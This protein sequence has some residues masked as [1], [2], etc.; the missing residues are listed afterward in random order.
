MAGRFRQQCGTR[1]SSQQLRRRSPEQPWLPRQRPCCAEVIAYIFTHTHT[2]LLIKSCRCI[3][4]CTS[5]E[6]TFS[7]NTLYGL[8]NNWSESF[9]AFDARHFQAR[10]VTRI[11]IPAKGWETFFSGAGGNFFSLYS[12]ESAD[13]REQHSAL[14][15]REHGQEARTRARL[16]AQTSSAS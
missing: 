4:Y 14:I 11:R 10:I 2:L 6:K 15:A 12:K 3:E 8:F 7:F 9:C 5:I 13:T 16:A 1:P